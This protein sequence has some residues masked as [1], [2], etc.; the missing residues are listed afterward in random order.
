MSFVA[1][2][3]AW[4]C[5]YK[6]RSGI[7]IVVTGVTINFIVAING[8]PWLYFALEFVFSKSPSTGRKLS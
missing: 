7:E 2:M 5:S 1:E 8:E 6:H 4:F 3:S